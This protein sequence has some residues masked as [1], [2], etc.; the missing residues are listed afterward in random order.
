MKIENLKM[1]FL[2]FKKEN[3][4]HDENTSKIKELKNKF[5]NIKNEEGFKSSK[6]KEKYRNKR[7]KEIAIE[8]GVS[9]AT[10]QTAHD[11][12]TDGNALG[13]DKA[14]VV[15]DPTFDVNQKKRFQVIAKGNKTPMASVKGGIIQK[16]IDEPIEGKR[17][18]FNPF[19]HH[20]FIDESGNAVKSVKGEVTVFNSAAYTNGEIE[21][22]SREQ[23]ET[24]EVETENFK[25]G[26]SYK[27]ETEKEK[28]DFEL[29]EM[30]T[31]SQEQLIKYGL[32]FSVST[33]KF[34]EGTESVLSNINPQ[35]QRRTIAGHW[36]SLTDNWRIRAHQGIVDQYKS[37]DKYI[38]AEPYKLATMTHSSSGAIEGAL[39][40]GVPFLD[41]DG[42]ID[43]KDSTLGTGLFT[44]LEKLG[45]DLPIFLEWIAAN[46]AKHLIGEGKETGLGD[47]KQVNIAIEDLSKGNEKLFNEVMKDVNVFRDAFLKIARDTGYLRQDAYNAW[48]GG[49]GYNF[50]IPFYRL[51]EDETGKSGPEAADRIINQPEVQ[52]YVGSTLPVKDLFSNMLQN[53]NF[54]AEASLRNQ[55][56]LK[57]LEQGVPM[58]VTR[59]VDK[60]TKNSVFARNNGQKVHYEIDEPLVL[61]SLQSL[62][63]GGWSNPAMSTLRNF[64]RYLT[65]G[66]TASPAFRL[67]NLI[68]DSIHSIA[69]SKISYNPLGNVMQGGKG[70][71]LKGRKLSELR[72]KMAFGG[73]EIHFGHIYGD[74]PNATKMLLD[75]NID[76]NTVMRYD[77]WTKGSKRFFKSKLGKGLDW[78]QEVGN[79]AENVNRAA[80]YQQL[81][82]KGIGHFEAS[83]QARDLLNFSRH[84]ANPAI[85]FLTQSIPFLNARIQGLDK[86]GRAFSQGQRA[87]LLTTLGA[88]SLA[89]IG[90]Y[91]AFK[92]DDD[93][94]DREQWD[95]DTYHWFK[96]P[97]S[98]TA[99]RIPRPFEV[100]AVGVM[101]ER[102]MEQMVDDDVHGSLLAERALHVITETFAFDYKPQLITPML[103]VYANK[104]T[105]T[106]RPVESM[107]MERLPPSER[108]YAYTSSAYVNTS[109]I[110]ELIPWKA[111]Q[112]SPVQIEH[113]VQGYFGWVGSSAVQAISF[114]DYPRKLTQFTSAESP[115]FMGFVKSVPSVQTRYKTEFYEAMR[116]MNEVNA[117]M[118]LYMKNGDTD[119]A[120]KVYNKNKNLIAWRSTYTRT[121]TQIIKI[122]RQIKFIEAQKNLSERERYEKVKQLNLLKAEIVRTLK[123]NVLA[124]EKTNDTRVKRPIWWK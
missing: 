1:Y 70:F 104:D 71:S 32:E 107:W 98:E 95:R 69:V 43:L 64:K 33:E 66:V 6:E 77:G 61:Q 20:L 84:G 53:F 90:L 38:G 39:N 48:T 108:K 120:M 2:I 105:F 65:I 87:Q 58:G 29:P 22:Y 14:I 96:L 49:A 56:G 93:F 45:K 80:L 79:T 18:F 99:F 97:G 10:L 68:R 63:W 94:K 74:N 100:G 54:L 15:K 118:N 46:R 13:Y 51:L 102:I 119:K 7:K 73:G 86:M 81:K 40:Y 85:R 42:A 83:Y 88:Y 26:V 111:I 72:A 113:L 23:G 47:I 101:F 25:S 76:L 8:T 110:L 57:T 103:E 3:R 17:I 59:K 35:R 5:A 124:Y 109:K 9:V 89:S 112:F 115:L 30:D 37:I 92:D 11:K 117:L 123:N 52:K 4:F 55:A 24:L 28:S 114:S 75:R 121:N 78:W 91:L 36:K 44:R 16:K 19:K 50:Y 21:Y 12:D 82:D 116:E 122:N 34:S 106:K 41:K 62:N 60:P 67:R 31:L 27:F